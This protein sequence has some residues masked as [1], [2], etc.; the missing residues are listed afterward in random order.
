MKLVK[1][2]TSACPLISFYPIVFTHGVRMGGQA[3]GKS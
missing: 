1:V 2:K 3:A